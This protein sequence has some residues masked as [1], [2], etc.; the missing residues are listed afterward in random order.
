MDPWNNSDANPWEFKETCGFLL[1]RSVDIKWQKASEP[2]LK[3]RRIAR[4]RKISD[5]KSL[6]GEFF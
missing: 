3:C 5:L 1:E 6:V 4:D 2:G